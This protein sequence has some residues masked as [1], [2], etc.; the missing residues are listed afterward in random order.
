MSRVYIWIAVVMVLFSTNIA[1]AESFTG[2]CTGVSEGDIIVV[3]HND[4]ECLVRIDCIDAPEMTQ[5]FGE[6]AK[7]FTTD[8]LFNKEVW[9]D[10]RRPDKNNRLMSKVKL[11]DKD[12]A[13][14]IV[15]A[16]YAWYVDKFHKDREIEAAEKD[17][18]EKKTGL[19]SQ[20]N[21][22]APWNYRRASSGIVPIGTSPQE[23]AA[24][25]ARKDMQ[26]SVKVL[27]SRK[28]VANTDFIRTEALVANTG[29]VPVKNVQVTCMFNN[30]FGQSFSKDTKSIGIIQPG[31]QVVVTFFSMVMA[32]SK[33]FDTLSDTLTVVVGE[34]SVKQLVDV[35]VEFYISCDE[36]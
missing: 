21:P 12:A 20:S 7:Q 10:V 25:T 13:L 11:R 30:F 16:G 17:A 24:N 27:K 33:G 26:P 32:Q 9:I 2:I 6:A 4:K 22:V 18:R 29:K 8:L 14:E 3:K 5:E 34:G 15:K 19:W 23:A 1:F 28:Y 31:E 35:R 36:M